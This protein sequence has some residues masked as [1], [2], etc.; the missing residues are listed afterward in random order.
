MIF[1]AEKNL[2]AHFHSTAEKEKQENPTKHESHVANE[3]SMTTL[4]TNTIE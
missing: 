2:W 3:Y 1:T 4:R